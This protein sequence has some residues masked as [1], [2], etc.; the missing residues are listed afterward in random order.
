MTIPNSITK[1]VDANIKTFADTKSAP[2]WKID[3]DIAD[4][5][6]EQDEEANPNIEA[7]KVQTADPLPSFFSISFF[8]K[9][10]WITPDRLNPKT[11]AQNVAK[12][13]SPDSFRD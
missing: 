1:F 13:I 3:F 10:D 9:N 5:A 7:L 8:L 4:A 12:N 6:Y 11:R 2:F